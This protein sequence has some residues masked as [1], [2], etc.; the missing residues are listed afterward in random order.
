MECPHPW[1]RF[2][3]SCSFSKLH[4]PREHSGRK[5]EVAQV[6]MPC[7]VAAHHS[8]IEVSPA[9]GANIVPRMVF[10]GSKSGGL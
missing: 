10:V 7:R 1:R 6:Q 2:C 8:S 3:V 5:A 9:E 4:S